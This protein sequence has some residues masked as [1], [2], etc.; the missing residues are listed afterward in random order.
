MYNSGNVIDN[1]GELVGIGVGVASS[2]DIQLNGTI[3]ND[4]G[5]TLINA[6]GKKITLNTSIDIASGRM[7]L[8][9]ASYAANSY[10]VKGVKNYYNI[11]YKNIVLNA[12][13]LN[14]FSTTPT[15]ALTSAKNAGLVISSN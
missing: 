6:S 11:T 9:A 8:M 10:T 5:N 2:K 14:S 7:S 3:Y 12:S 15:T 1:F 13:D 4:A